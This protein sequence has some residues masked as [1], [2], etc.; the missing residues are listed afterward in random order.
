MNLVD[1]IALAKQGY[2]P[3][4]VERLIA[5]ADESQQT[6]PTQADTDDTQP[7]QTD[8]Y[9]EEIPAQPTQTDTEKAQAD[10]IAEL[11]KQLADTNKALKTAQDF[12]RRQNAQPLSTQSDSDRV[13]E[14]ARS[15]M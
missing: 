13:N 6:Q 11:E 15:F 2:K 5:L 1:L 8:T 4:D 10:R 14:W 3:A 12:N 9:P 7:T